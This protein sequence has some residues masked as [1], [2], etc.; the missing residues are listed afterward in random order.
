MTRREYYRQHRLDQTRT[1]LTCGTVLSPDRRG[2]YCAT[3]DH[4]ERPLA[5][6]SLTTPCRG[7]G[8][9]LR[10]GRSLCIACLGGA[11]A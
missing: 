10:G 11:T 9:P 5:E 4:E 3:H 7:C 6:S 2:F 1:C 8:R